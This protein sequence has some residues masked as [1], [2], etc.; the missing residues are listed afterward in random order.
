MTETYDEA[1]KHLGIKTPAT[2]DFAVTNADWGK[3]ISY[4]LEDLGVKPPPKMRTLAQLVNYLRHGKSKPGGWR[5]YKI[6]V[7]MAIEQ[8]RSTLCGQRLKDFNVHYP[9]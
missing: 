2:G 6:Q 5:P 3:R 1:Y 4:T 7:K 9:K 8:F